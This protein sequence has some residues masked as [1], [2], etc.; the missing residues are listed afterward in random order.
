MLEASEIL[1]A[2]ILIVDD[3]EANV[4]LLEQVL[5]NSGYTRISSTMDPRAVF[6][7]HQAERYD[8]ILLDLQM[9]EMDGFEVMEALKVIE[10]DA[11]LPVLVITAQPGHKLRALQGGAKDFISKPFDL[12]EVK[13][14]IHNML[15]VRLLYQKLGN[16][17]KELELAVLERTAELRDSEAR[18]QRFTEL[19]SDWYWEQ[20]AQGELTKFYGPVLEMLGIG[21]GQEQG[22]WNAAERAELDANIASRQP[23]LD[24]IY[25]RAKAD[26]S[27]QYLQVSGEPMFDAGS[28][29]VGYRGIGMDVTERMRPDQKHKLF[30]SAVDA[31]SQGVLLVDAASMQL[32][33]A[34]EAVCRL[35]GYSLKELAALDLA[36]LGLGHQAQLKGMFAGLVVGAAPLRQSVELRRKD[37]SLLTSNIAWRAVESEA[38]LVMVGVIT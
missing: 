7:L 19:S 1:N 24:F 8:L 2:S 17:S 9:P 38:G 12:V 18:F 22:G 26:G 3:Q 31:I 29:F 11:Y 20:N 30:R 15:E 32:A 16:Y 36:D 27:M 13:T 28:R 21:D 6:A 10:S 33:D 23:F 34:S 25:S 4:M 37:G 35:S 14:R 5:R